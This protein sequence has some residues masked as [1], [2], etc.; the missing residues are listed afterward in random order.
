[1]RIYLEAREIPFQ[2]HDIST[3][4]D[5]RRLMTETYDST[6]T[7][8]LVIADEV[9][10]GL[11]LPALT[12]TSIRFHHRTRYPNPELSNRQSGS[13]P[14]RI[15]FHRRCRISSD[16]AYPP[17]WLA[18]SSPGNSSWRE[19]SSTPSTHCFCRKPE[20][21]SLSWSFSRCLQRARRYGVASSSP[22]PISSNA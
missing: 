4:L 13:S 14:A 12:S 10:T 17:P 5:S 19:R 3:D 7:P 6:E 21:R 20:Q 8:T 11:I 16:G 1:M 15:L 2:E 22:G 18:P 9:I